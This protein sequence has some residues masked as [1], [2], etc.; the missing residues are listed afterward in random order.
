MN[1]NNVYVLIHSPL[2]GPLTW[3]LVADVMHQRHL[4]V[5]IPT[6]E[7]SPDS[8]EPFWKQHADSVSQAL[9][10][11]P[12]DTPVT[13]VA[14]S[15]AGPLLP[16]IR[17]SIPNPVHAYVFVDAGLPGEEATRLSLMQSEESDWARQFQGYLE[18]GGVFPNWSS[19]DLR[20]IIPDESLREQMVSEIQP[21]ALDFF[22]EPIPG[23]KAWPDAACVYILFSEPYQRAAA[24]ARQLGWP[25]YE[26][27]A[28]HFHMLVD[29]KAVAELV[30]NSVNDLPSNP[31]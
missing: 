3:K 12:E 26:L 23:L 10:H 14:H 27:E 16:V 30:V 20:E 2:V 28:G 6:L 7:D 11:I 19:D 15:G 13:L 8:K 9:Q 18:G 21:R 29:P 5:I 22:T 31:Q 17:G 25:T 1:K 4:D 24:Q